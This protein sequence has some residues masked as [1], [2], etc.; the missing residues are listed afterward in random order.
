MNCIIVDD[1]QHSIDILSDYIEKTPKLV[2]KASYKNPIDA[3]Q[4]IQSENIDLAF[5]DVQMP[6]LT[7]IQFSKL[8]NKNTKIIL[9]TAYSEYALEGFDLNIVD[10]LLKPIAFERYLQAVN[11]LLSINNYQVSKSSEDTHDEFIFVKADLKGKYIKINLCDI[12]FIE[13]LG[14]Y[15]KIFTNNGQII[16]QLKLKSIEKQLKPF[17]FLRVH[18]SFL[19]PIKKIENIEGHKIQ[20]GNHRI[21][22]GD[23]YKESFFNAITDKM[24]E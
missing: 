20:I 6:N 2:L 17:G 3:L 12:L 7:G 11:K 14:N 16:T 19:V 15:Q 5:L 10:Y 4:Y 22:L 21:P 13:G 24:I 18:K 23:M 9:C 1:E 8:L